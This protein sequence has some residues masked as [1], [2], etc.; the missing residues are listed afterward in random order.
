MF[1]VAGST[2]YH[3][4]F[5]SSGHGGSPFPTE[6]G[7]GRRFCSQGLEIESYREVVVGMEGDCCPELSALALESDR[8][9]SS[10]SQSCDLGP[11][12]LMLGASLVLI[13]KMGQQR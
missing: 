4:L 6:S 3:L 7:P 5:M 1:P 12:V 2:G 11:A 9:D 13:W 10:N 8:P